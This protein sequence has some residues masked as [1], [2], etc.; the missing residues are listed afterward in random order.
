[1]YLSNVH[2]DIQVEQVEIAPNT[3]HVHQWLEKLIVSNTALKWLELS[4]I[5]AGLYGNIL[6]VSSMH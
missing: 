4:V 3:S 6:V 5:C 1:M 2:T